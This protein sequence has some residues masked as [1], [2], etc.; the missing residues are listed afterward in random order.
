[1]ENDKLFFD[2]VIFDITDRKRAEQALHDA[3]LNWQ[4]TFDSTQDAICLFDADQRIITCN[5]TMQELL[6]AKNAEDLIGQ[7]CWEAVHG[8]TGPVSDCPHYRMQSS[9]KRETLELEKDGR[10]YI[11]VTDPILDETQSLVGA[12]H[13]MRDITDRR[14]AEKALIRA[15]RKLALLSG[16]TRHDINNQLL[17]LNGFLKRLHAKALDPLLEDYFNRIIHASSRISAMIRFTKEYEQIGVG[18][19]VW[20]D[21]HTLVESAAHDVVLGNTQLANDIPAGAEVFADPLIVKVFY[22]LMDNAVRYG[23]KITTIRFSVL[24]SGDDRIILCEDDGNGVAADE[25][26]K[27]FEQGFGKNTGLG[28]FL[29][30]EIL[31]ITGITIKETGEP[32]KGARFEMVVPKGMFR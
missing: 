17:V 28:L 8:T 27:I 31:D 4:S 21:C 30:R 26:E 19:P 32:G 15:N 7:H 23:G 1:M 16:I 10:W 18:A 29:A 12:V 24:E 3:A 9:H 2:G 6:G 20:Q 14:R 11:V 25:K 13:S 5:R 22:N